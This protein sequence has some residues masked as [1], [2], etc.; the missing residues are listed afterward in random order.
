LAEYWAVS[1]KHIR[2]KECEK[3]GKV[4]EERSGM[5][6]F[7]PIASSFVLLSL[8]VYLRIDGFGCRMI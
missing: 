7:C 1:A 4:V 2:E 3:A 6:G 8:V 5:G